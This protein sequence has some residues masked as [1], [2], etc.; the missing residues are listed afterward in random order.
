MRSACVQISLRRIGIARILFLVPF[1]IL[2][3]RA[4]HLS[5][6]DRSFARGEDQTR[7]VLELAPG[8]GA[9]VDSSGAEL[10]L[11]VESPSIYAIPSSIDDVAVAAA[12]LAPILGWKRQKLVDRM[13]GRQSF[14]FLARWVTPER[15]TKKS[16][17]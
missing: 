11:S 6:D 14:F 13:R 16:N 17:A 1:A 2:G 10:A 4:A 3:L 15:S 12:R 9:I 5:V 7:R 8:R